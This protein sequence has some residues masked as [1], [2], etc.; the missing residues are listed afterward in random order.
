MEVDR[1]I[2]DLDGLPRQNGELVFAAPWQSRI[3]GMAVALNE[4]GAY[5]WE[6]FRRRLVE[7]IA[8]DADRDYYGSWL[9]AFERLLIDAGV[10]SDAELARRKTEYASQERD[11]F[12]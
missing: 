11:D 4:R 2:A 3:F 1:R 10:L 9:G 12:V 5:D 6:D 8:R 7:E